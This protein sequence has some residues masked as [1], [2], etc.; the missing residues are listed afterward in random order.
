MPPRDLIARS[1]TSFPDRR[2]WSGQVEYTT[3]ISAMYSIGIIDVKTFEFWICKINPS[4]KGLSRAV[5]QF[6]TPPQSIETVEQAA[7][8][9]VPTQGGGKFVE[10][11]GNLFKDVRISGTV[12]FRPNIPSKEL[13]P[14]LAKAGGPSIGTPTSFLPDFLTKDN[15]GLDPKEVTGFDEMMFLRNIFRA[16]FDIKS[17]DVDANRVALVWL[18]DKESEAY[19][20]E[21]ISFTTNRDKG[22]PL[23][24]TYNIQLRTLYK[25]DVVRPYETDSVNLF[26][27]IGNALNMLGSIV[28]GIVR[29]LKTIANFMD[30]LKNFPANLIQ[31]VFSGWTDILGGIAA[32]RTAGGGFSDYVT[33]SIVRTMKSQTTQLLS[34]LDD[35]YNQQQQPAFG[36]SVPY[37]MEGELGLVRHSLRQLDRFA[38][39]ILTND[40]LWK[41]NKNIQVSDYS[42]SY[43]TETG[44]A[45]PTAGSPLNPTNINMPD[46]AVEQEV[47]GGD[48]IRTL[49]LKYLGDEA[50]WKKLALMNNLKPPYISAVGGDGV[51][52]PGGTILIPR[53]TASTVALSVSRTVNPDA[54]SEALRPMMKRY[55]RD[56]RL[57][58][59][60][61]ELRDFTTTS[62]GDIDV[63]EGI[64]NVIQAIKIKFSTE[65][66][67]LPTHPSFGAKYSVGTKLGM[68]TVQEFALN[69][70]RT[71]FQDPR[72]EEINSMEIFAVGDQLFNKTRLKLIGAD[73]EIP[74][75]F[76]VR[77]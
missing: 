33:E 46:T 14:G 29:A 30:Y 31:S 18:Y 54:S 12:G 7:T 75:T 74:F 39:A 40:G 13:F 16:Y 69:T 20:V 15:R 44:E 76:S 50:Q 66:G 65:V 45:S 51:L 36:H 57:L 2:F 41:E 49:A 60:G 10:S 9:I 5:Y 77:R 55:G 34:A 32:I 38:T 3:R 43:L 64:D 17:S 11:Q 61:G 63:V 23:G 59:A 37:M 35:K 53:T 22:N 19:V 6:T 24:W 73:A 71:F 25:L 47:T 72:I 62:G 26:S 70:R 4:V 27:A 56:L 1:T 48:T 21:P 68:A 67:E 28:N 8:T 58:E 42:R 52:K